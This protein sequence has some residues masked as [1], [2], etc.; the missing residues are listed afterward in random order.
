MAVLQMKR[1]G[2]LTA[3]V[4]VCFEFFFFFFNLRGGCP[5]LSWSQDSCHILLSEGYKHG[6]NDYPQPKGRNAQPKISTNLVSHFLLGKQTFVVS[7][8]IQRGHL[9]SQP[10]SFHT[11]SK[12][13][14]VNLKPIHSILPPTLSSTSPWY[15][16]FQNQCQVK[17]PGY[18][19]L[20]ITKLPGGQM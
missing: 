19:S 15:L 12:L 5:S 16:Q 4:Y 1:L 11:G 18:F 17:S 2:F 10:E 3:S 13:G 14:Q 9:S 20:H 7:W 6:K 8:R